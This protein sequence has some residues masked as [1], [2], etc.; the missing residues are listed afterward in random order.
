MKDDIETHQAATTVRAVETIHEKFIDYQDVDAAL[1]FLRANAAS[2]QAVDINEKKLMRKVDWMIM[3]LMFACYYLQYT[4]KTL[5][6]C[7]DDK[8]GSVL[9]IDSVVRIDNGC[10]R[11]YAHAFQWL[12][13]PG[14][15]LLRLLPFL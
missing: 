12:L 4:D 11:R 13:E 6:K 14:N 9:T 8:D 5:R 2:G 3:P 10:H 15:C 7:R 1:G